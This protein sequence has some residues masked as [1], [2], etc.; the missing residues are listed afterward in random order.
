MEPI[1]YVIHI[2]LSQ[3]RMNSVALGKGFF[4][5]KYVYIVFVG[6]CPISHVLV[7]AQ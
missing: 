1:Y 3:A 4:L 2:Y 6:I 5:F 7:S